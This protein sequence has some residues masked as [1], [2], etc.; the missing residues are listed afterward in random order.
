MD[1]YDDQFE[2]EEKP[3]KYIYPQ[4]S[5]SAFK[6]DFKSKY[7]PKPRVEDENEESDSFIQDSEPENENKRVTPIPKQPSQTV[8]NT[9]KLRIKEFDLNKNLPPYSSSDYNVVKI[10]VI[11]KPGCFAPGTPVLMRNKTI[12]KIEE[13]KVGDKIMGDDCTERTVQECLSDIDDM[14][15]IDP[16]KGT[17]YVVN[18]KHDLVLVN[19]DSLNVVD[20]SVMMKEENIVEISVEEYLRPHNIE[21]YKQYHVYRCKE[22]YLDTIDSNS[23]GSVPSVPSVPTVPTVK[24]FKERYET[25]LFTIRYKGYSEYYGFRIDKNRRF[26]LG[27]LEVV[28]N[29]GK[30]TILRSII[31]AKAHMCPAIQV[32]NGTEDSSGFYSKLCPSVFIHDKF[33]IQSMSKFAQR[34]KIA[35][36][37]VENPWAM[38]IIDDCTDDPKLLRHQLIQSFYK[39]GRHWRLIHV[40]A[41]QYALDIL[42][43]IR[44]SIDYTFILRE[45]NTRNRKK[46]YENYCPGIISEEQFNALMDAFTEDFGCLVFCNATISN[47]IEDC[48][49]YFKADVNFAPPNFRFG[50]N[51]I[52]EYND[53]RYDPNFTPPLLEI[54]DKKKRK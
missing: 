4:S 51:T 2:Y 37:Y 11:G 24:E 33:D 21:K 25:S 9:V 36:K 17:P 39:N 44:T 8:E 35:M 34:Q 18:R 23:T 45:T 31:A 46:I 3:K 50:A 27:T 5:H 43:G 10:V 20:D 53:E 47:K 28:R 19:T 6:R 54:E 30:S 29:T 13:V 26:L 52:W 1:D 15:I 14:Y 12:K 48:I 40:L 41:L 42:P 32:Y 49:F 22:S 38:M 7:L 16:L